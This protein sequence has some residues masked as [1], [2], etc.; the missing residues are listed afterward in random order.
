M[1]KIMNLSVVLVCTMMLLVSCES[2]YE[3]GQKMAKKLDACVE[4]YLSAS[5]QVGIDFAGQL[6][7]DYTSRAKAVQDYMLLE[8]EC[9]NKYLQKWLSLESKAEQ[10]YRSLKKSSDKYKY[11]DGLR[12]GE[13]YVFLSAP[14]AE[15][16]DI[17]TIVIQQLRQIN[18][19]KPNNDRIASD[20]VGHTL[21]EGKTKCYYPSYWNLKI[22]EG[23]IS[24][25]VID[26]VVENTSDKYT[27]RVSMLLSSE[28]C[29]YN[30]KAVVRYVLDDLT[31]WRIE[32]VQSKG[33]DKVRTHRYDDCVRY[34]R[35]G[36]GNGHLYV[37]NNCEIA[38]EVAGRELQSYDGWQTF[39]VIVKPHES[40]LISFYAIEY[41]IDYVE[42]P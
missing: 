40:S 24:N 17:P 34:Y 13:H 35:G 37:E 21:S 30:T 31:D 6:P 9:Y 33:M 28:T 7:G 39:C 25:L 15:T 20:L 27:I 8:E 16:M 3:K 22:E 12:T 1:K 38:L 32:Y 26:S 5:Q 14:S 42:R 41:Q 23:A 29:S 2:S 18:P 36:F 10:T 11:Q 4:E 19:P